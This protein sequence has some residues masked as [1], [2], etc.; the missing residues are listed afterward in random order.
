MELQ[1]T[2]SW[3]KERLGK[4]TSSEIYK[5]MS[6]PRTK[7]AKER[8]DLSEAAMTY[9]LQKIVE[10]VGGFI[11]EG[12]SNATIYGT[13]Q[14]DTA[15]YW[16]EQKTGC[17]VEKVGFI[18]YSDFYGGSPDRKAYD[19]EDGLMGVVE[20]KC[21][22]NSTNHLW[23]CMIKDHKYFKGNHKEYWW[24]CIS[25][26]LVTGSEFCDFVSFDPRI[27]NLIGFFRYRIYKD[28]VIDDIELLIANILKASE[29]K[30]KL[31]IQLGLL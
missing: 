12:D 10:E 27:D 5:L 28:E 4:F 9:I 25:Q 2:E 30:T 24:Q 15:A 26:I 1:R 19:R 22:Y 11:P 13:E 3:R 20:I 7:E 6:E 16:Y 18:A 23:H 8:G 29:V 14:E 31:K 17:I 21:P